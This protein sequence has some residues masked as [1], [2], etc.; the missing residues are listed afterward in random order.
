MKKSL[1]INLAGIIFH[2]DDDAYEKL[3]WYLDNLEKKFKK[4]ID[5]KEIIGDIEN[6]IAEIFSEKIRKHKQAITLE[7]VNEV[8]KTL[9]NPAEITD[10]NVTNE[11]EQ[12]KT[13][14]KWFQQKLYRDIDNGVI[15]G[16]CGGLGAYFKIDPAIFRILFLVALLLGGTSLLIYLVLW[17]AIPAARTPLQKLEMHGKP[18]NENTIEDFS[19]NNQETTPKKQWQ[20]FFEQLISIAKVVFQTALK[21]V[22]VIVGGLLI[23]AGLAASLAIVFTVISSYQVFNIHDF[24]ISF[25]SLFYYAIFNKDWVLIF[26]YFL[27]IFIPIL[28]IIYLGL[29]LIFR[30]KYNDRH[31]WLVGLLLWIL[32]FILLIFSFFRTNKNVQNKEIIHEEVTLSVTNPILYIYKSN[33]DTIINRMKA[34]KNF[35]INPKSYIA[36]KNT[37]IA[38]PEVVIE[39]S[40][41]NKP[42]LVLLKKAFGKN[43][44]EAYKA[45]NK[46]RYNLIFSDSTL[47]LMEYYHIEDFKDLKLQQLT[48]LIQLPI[49]QKV[50]IDNSLISLIKDAD[51][52]GSLWLWELANNYWIMT[53]KGLKKLY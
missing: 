31:I 40:K 5:R 38:K 18:I 34:K 53:N 49:N 13:H 19:R 10:E 24:N 39:Q 4:E 26:S 14:T 21:I 37:I 15:G 35:L 8:I 47:H 30:F 32:G 29:R 23:I 3:Q 12:T 52:D 6:R 11:Y 50:Y 36:Y 45:A 41:D 42:K 1:Q 20:L 2:I 16:V 51:I 17:I 33:N 27:I 43:S 22:I 44:D 46:I 7:D 28:A 48:I 25:P 9:G